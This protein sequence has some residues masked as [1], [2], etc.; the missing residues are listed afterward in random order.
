MIPGLP[1]RDIFSTYVEHLKPYEFKIKKTDEYSASILSD[2]IIQLLRMLLL[3]PLQD[4][5]DLEY[6]LIKHLK[7]GQYDLERMPFIE[8]RIMHN[9]FISESKEQSG[10]TTQTE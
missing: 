10:N 3:E 6:F 1:I 5:I 7:L 9:K 8:C 4:V 2:T